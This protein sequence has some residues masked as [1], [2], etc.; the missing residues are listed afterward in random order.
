MKL[1]IIV[2]IVVGGI[3]FITILKKA[4]RKYDEDTRIKM[5][6][7]KAEHLNREGQSDTIRRRANSLYKEADE[8]RRKGDF[9]REERLRKEA[10]EYDDD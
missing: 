3:L 5:A 2:G 8:A 4:W 1:L 7:L 10:E 9:K 6:R